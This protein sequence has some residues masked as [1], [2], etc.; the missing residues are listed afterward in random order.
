ME[1]TLKAK[2]LELLTADGHVD[3]AQALKNNNTN[4]LPPHDR[5]TLIK[6]ANRLRKGDSFITVP[7]GIAGHFPS[8]GGPGFLWGSRDGFG[9]PE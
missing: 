8:S 4:D 7:P 6:Y 3:V 5:D 2:L 9:D 1:N